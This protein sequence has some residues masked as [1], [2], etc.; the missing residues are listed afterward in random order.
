M[1]QWANFYGTE[2]CQPFVK[3]CY[4]KFY[5]NPTNGLVTDIRL[6]TAMSSHKTFPLLF[7]FMQNVERE[8]F[9]ISVPLYVVLYS[10]QV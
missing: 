9:Q 2:T 10:S 5:E 6:Q 4:T 8:W 3:N 7:Y 1:I